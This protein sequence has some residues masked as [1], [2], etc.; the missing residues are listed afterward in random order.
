MSNTVIKEVETHKHLGVYLSNDGSWHEH[1]EYIKQK[2][3]AR[4]NIM[5]KLKFILDRKSLE[6]IYMSFVRPILE[7]ADVVWDNTTKKH[8]NDL[9]QVQLE[10]M[11]IISGCTKLVSIANL[12][13]ET[14]FETLKTRRL[15]HKSTLFYKIVNE[16]VPSYLT[17]LIPDRVGNITPYSLRNSND[18]RN[19]HCN[20]QLYANSFLPSSISEWNQLPP[21]IKNSQSVASF[22]KKLENNKQRVPLHYYSGQRLAQIHHTRLRTHCSSLNEHLYSKNIIES[23]L[24]QCGEIEDTSHYLFHCKQYDYQRQILLTKI[25]Q[26]TIPTLSTF[27]FG[28]PQLT[29]NDNNCIFKLVQE[30]IIKTKRFAT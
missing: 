30:Y 10:A 14:C 11:R 29:L 20:S 24:C 25:R 28:E 26:I 27:L 13:K 7:Y 21:D 4:I 12:Y 22:K 5:Q 6:T 18:M 15:K 23:P 16:Q 8:E 1:I 9:E 19:V 17:E 3:W 2:A